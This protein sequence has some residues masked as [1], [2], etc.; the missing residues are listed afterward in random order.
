MKKLLKALSFVGLLMALSTMGVWS[1]LSLKLPFTGGETW[2]CAQGNYNDPGAPNETHKETSSMKYAWDFNWGLGEDDKGKPVVA[3]AA[4]TVVYADWPKNVKNEPS[5]WGNTV[6]INYGD[7]SYGKL[8]HLDSKSVNV[9]DHI[10]QGQEIGKCGGTGGWPSHIHYQTQN[11][12]DVNGQSISSTFTEVC[13]NNGVPLERHYYVSANF[14]PGSTNNISVGIYADGWHKQN[15]SSQYFIPYSQPFIDLYVAAVAPRSTQD[16]TK[17]PGK[18]LEI[19]GVP[20]S[21]VTQRTPNIYAQEF[22]KDGI[23]Y[24]VVLN[25]NVYNMSHSYLGVCY[26]ICG[27]IRTFW[28]PARDGAPVTNEYYVERGGVKYAVQWFEPTDNNYKLLAYGLDNNLFIPDAEKILNVP[29]DDN[30][31]QHMLQDKNKNSGVG[32]GEDLE[33]TPTPAGSIGGAARY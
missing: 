10:I 18:G 14:A 15:M 30:F 8:C 31:N 27:R 6:I 9:N 4:G 13:E 12:G 21:E 3:P 25:P 1:E 22:N 28:D 19:Y 26:P 24:T 23:Q 7:G 11:S 16:Q 32:G 17:I 20:V 29:Q 33:P 2:W 5:T